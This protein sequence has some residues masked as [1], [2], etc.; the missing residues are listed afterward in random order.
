MKK[1][2][3][4][5]SAEHVDRGISH[6]FKSD[7]LNGNKL[8]GIR[9]VR[10]KVIIHSV[11]HYIQ[12]YDKSTGKLQSIDF[13]LNPSYTYIEKLV[14]DLNSSCRDII[15]FSVINNSRL[16]L[17]LPD[18]LRINSM[19]SLTNRLLG[20]VDS[21]MKCFP[22]LNYMPDYYVKFHTDSIDL[23]DGIKIKLYQRD[24]TEFYGAYIGSVPKIPEP[25]KLNT[26]KSPISYLGV[27]INGLRDSKQ[28]GDGPKHHTV[29]SIETNHEIIHSDDKM[30]VSTMPKIPRLSNFIFIETGNEFSGCKFEIEAIF[31]TK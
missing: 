23:L 4:S 7:D 15:K 2:F 18:N 22:N 14:F 11:K 3:I 13:N 20:I 8:I 1:S 6:K 9:D 19:G 10:V 21:S 17:S 5:D 24:E 30:Q 29:K 25:Q 31:D 27:K 26:D 12:L 28:Y 16:E